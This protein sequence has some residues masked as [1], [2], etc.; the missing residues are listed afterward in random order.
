MASNKDYEVGYK[1]PPKVTRF[2][3]GKSGNPKG[4]PKNTRN[5]VA[6]IDEEL[7]KSVVLKENGR[8]ITLTKR[9]AL[10]KRLVNNA[11][12]GDPKSTNSLIQMSSLSSEREEDMV[13]LSKTDQEQFDRLRQRIL[14]RERRK[15]STT[16]K[17]D[18]AGDRHA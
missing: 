7:D 8:T 13:E 15:G 5:L 3:K 6:L 18:A 9:E 12:S 17:L 16:P 14:D 11:L 10:A 1:K 4:R 2:N